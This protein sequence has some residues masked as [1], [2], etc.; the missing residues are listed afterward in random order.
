MGQAW[1]GSRVPGRS[2]VPQ[3]I[4]ATLWGNQG[5]Q[6]A[7]TGPQPQSKMVAELGPGHRCSDQIPVQWVK[8]V[9]S[10]CSDHIDNTYLCDRPTQACRS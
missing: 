6:R 9:K 1:E 5:L 3:V 10:H 7:G 2:S 4:L 8:I